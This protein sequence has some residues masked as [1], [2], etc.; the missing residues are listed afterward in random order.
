MRCAKELA[1]SVAALPELAGVSRSSV[2][3]TSTS[4]AGCS[5]VVGVIGEVGRCCS[6]EECRTTPVEGREASRV[7]NS[8]SKIGCS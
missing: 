3:S 8:N 5:G 4:A 7:S 6:R 2:R 1:P